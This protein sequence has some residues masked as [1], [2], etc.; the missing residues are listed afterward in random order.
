MASL[1]MINSDD[2]LEALRL[3][4][5]GDTAQWPLA[6]MRLGAQLAQTQTQE[7]ASNLPDARRAFQNRAILSLGLEHLQNVN[8]ESEAL[9]RQR[10]VEGQDA[11]VVANTLSVA[12]SSLYYRQR[13]AINQLT[14]ILTQLEEDASRGWREKML[15][16]LDQPTYTELVGIDEPY[17]AISEA[18][19]D[20]SEHFIV[21]IDGLGGL[22]KTAIVDHIAREILHTIQFDEVAWVTA[23]QTHLST[24]GRLQVESG[25]PALTF[26][27]LIE[28]LSKQ[29]ELPNNFGGSQ[30]QKQRLVQKYLRE[31][32]CLVVI[33]NLETVADQN[34]LLPEL[35][36]WQNPSKFLLTT[37]H[38]L[39]DQPGV[40]SYSMRELSETA[41][42]Q[43]VRN[44][45]KR[46][47]FDSLAKANDEDIR[48]IYEMVGG[49]PLALKLIVGQLRF[50]S[51]PRVLTRLAESQHN[52]SGIGLF[53]YIYQESWESLND[54]SKTILLI[55]TQAGETGFTLDHI[56]SLTDLPDVRVE[57]CL[58]ELILISLVD[59]KGSFL[60]RRYSL[61]RL[62]EIFLLEMFG[63]V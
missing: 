20:K 63:N 39:I 21:S 15:A 44:E 18:L 55:L 24:R 52:Q 58:E 25:K 28:A 14:E 60:D 53:D 9:L 17:T 46:T 27:M 33:D 10:F 50:Y 1:N 36:K 23:K 47:G 51:L 56:V 29:F 30:L 37:R 54:D 49:N 62:T 48:Q 43:L 61:H 6:H 13:Q 16:R 41:A 8:P 11:L 35:K 26:L 2:V 12:Q 34:A 42:F 45:A 40:Y 32:A 59:L 31:R 22:G 5:G 7:L 4:A 19:L 3:W 57:Q 38:R